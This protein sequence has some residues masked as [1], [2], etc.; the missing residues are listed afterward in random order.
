MAPA[1]LPRLVPLMV[2][3]SGGAGAFKR[4][5]AEAAAMRS[6]AVAFVRDALRCECSYA[7]ANALHLAVAGR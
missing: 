6:A 7:C 5:A 2:A 1:L 4:S 3:G